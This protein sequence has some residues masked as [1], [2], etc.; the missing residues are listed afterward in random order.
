MEPHLIDLKT[1]E[2]SAIPSTY[3]E[4]HQVEIYFSRWSLCV[5]IE[6]LALMSF[7]EKLGQTE[8]LKDPCL[9]DL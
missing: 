5:A 1:R 4:I 2:V 8:Q 3:S 7:H 6:D 9:S